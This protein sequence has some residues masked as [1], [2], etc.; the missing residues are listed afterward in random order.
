[1]KEDIDDRS[2]SGWSA[3]EDLSPDTCSPSCWAFL[4]RTDEE[5]QLSMEEWRELYKK[6]TDALKN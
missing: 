2:Y 1:M 5:T 4:N 6:Q 3:E